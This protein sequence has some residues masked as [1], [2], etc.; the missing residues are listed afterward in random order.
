MA[1]P[2]CDLSFFRVNRVNRVNRLI[3]LIG[4]R[5]MIWMN[6]YLFYKYFAPGRCPQGFFLKND[7]IYVY[8]CIFYVFWCILQVFRSG[9]VPAGTFFSG[10]WLYLCIFMHIYVSFMNFY[11]FYMY[12]YI[13]CVVYV[14]LCVS[15]AFLRFLLEIDPSRPSV[16]YP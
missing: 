2:P 1:S 7:G 10:K 5:I 15:D 16:S 13:I 8:L 6:F 14:F 9:L 4:F 11:A 12:S 3:G